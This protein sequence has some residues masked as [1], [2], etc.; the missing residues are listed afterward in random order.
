MFKKIIFYFLVNVAVL[1][2]KGL[3]IECI[4]CRHFY[5]DYKCNLFARNKKL[6]EFNV[7]NY[8]L[9]KENSTF[10]YLSILEARSNEQLCGKDAQCFDSVYL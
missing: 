3:C 8:K 5:G 4:N 2:I 6:G 10:K 9:L 7:Y 1:K